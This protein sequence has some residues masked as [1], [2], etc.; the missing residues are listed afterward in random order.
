M[1]RMD[2]KGLSGGGVAIGFDR[3]DWMHGMIGNWGEERGA[4][5]KV[6]NKS[7]E[8][9]RRLERVER[10]GARFSN[11]KLVMLPSMSWITLWA[12]DFG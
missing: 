12:S 6:R 1:T 4:R 3:L 2:Q 9:K 5:S 10:V 7:P 8:N 11:L